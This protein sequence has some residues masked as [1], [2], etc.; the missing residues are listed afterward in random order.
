[1]AAV[2]KSL[3]AI[4]ALLLIGAPKGAPYGSGGPEGLADGGRPFRAAAITAQERPRRIISLVPATTEMLF[5]MGAGDRVAGVSNYDR[6]PPEVSRL[7]KV[8]GLLDPDVERVLSLKPD[9]VIVYETQA[10]LKR[11]LERAKVPIFGYSHRGLAD[12]TETMRA[13]GSRVGASAAADAAAS[14]VEQQLAA[15]G[16]RVAGRSRPKT[17]LV[18]G[19]EPGTLRR[20]MA[21]G[22]Y[23]FLHDVLEIAGGADVLGD[24]R[25]QSVDLSTEMILTRA[26]EVIIELHYGGDM[27]PESFEAE[28]QA[29]NALPSVPAVRARRIYLLDGQEFVV[30]GP[31]IV[32]A[33]ERFARTLHPEAFQ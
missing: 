11:Q 17:L 23:G 33:A 2:P 13:L 7:P 8:G 25:R 5:A 10:D 14:R 12:I 18:F 29:W 9:L 27:T 20:V 24:L 1:M 22:G 30:P 19:R 21:S 28:R 26:P 16:R 3:A 15:I 32:V 31:R 6:F 4:V